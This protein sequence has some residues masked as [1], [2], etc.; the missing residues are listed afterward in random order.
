MILISRKSETGKSLDT[1]LSQ[2]PSKSQVSGQFVS[3]ET[4]KKRE[5]TSHENA[6]TAT[7]AR[8]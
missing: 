6:V 4:E 7:L 2:K 5:R 1:S 8:G 3:R